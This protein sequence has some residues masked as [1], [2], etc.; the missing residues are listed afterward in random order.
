MKKLPFAA[1][2]LAFSP[3]VAQNLPPTAPPAPPTP[4]PP[5][6]SGKGEL[7]YVSTSGNTS[8]QTLGFSAEAEYKPDPW[9]FL[10]KAA[11]VRA[12]ADGEVKAKSFAALLKG[13]RKLFDH[14]DGFVQAGYVH[15]TFAGIDARYAGEAGIGYGVLTEGRHL[16]HVEVG[17]GY[18]KENRVLGDDRSFATARAGL[19]YK[20][21]ISKTAEFTEEPQFVEDLK[22]TNDWRFN[23]VAALSASISTVFSLKVSHTFNYLREPPAGFGR[24][25]TITAAAVVA[26]F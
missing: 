10:A 15:N 16:L 3:L 5:L 18:T 25:D 17:L 24:T 9:A 11:F 26:K 7:S 14:V 13:S 22:D 12:E 20:C 19:Q 6:W 4:P 21:V 8:T 1:I 23:N 2:C